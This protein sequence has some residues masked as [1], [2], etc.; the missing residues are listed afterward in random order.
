MSNNH[1]NRKQAVSKLKPML[2]TKRQWDGFCDYLD[3]MISEQHTKLEKSDNIVSIHR[4]QGAIDAFR[5]L[6]YLREEASE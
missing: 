2:S 4:A 3:I 1:S 6:K 5:Y